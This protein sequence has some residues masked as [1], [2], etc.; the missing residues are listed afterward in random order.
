[1]ARRPAS[2]VR[3]SCETQATSSRR[4]SSSRRSRARDCASRSLVRSSS[5]AS[6]RSSAGPDDPDA[7]NS[8]LAP[9]R[10]VSSASWRDQRDRTRPTRVA[11]STATTPATAAT[12]S[13][14]PKS[15][16]ERNIARA[17]PTIPAVTAPTATRATVA[18]STG[19]E[20]RRS[21]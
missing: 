7:T 4:A 17:V 5:A 3:R 16:A 18:D 13:V 11:T 2:G 6:W 8:P 9:N 20:R 1:M 19:T 12:M 14:T 10:R 21:R 15:W